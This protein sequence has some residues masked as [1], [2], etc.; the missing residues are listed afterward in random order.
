MWMT[1]Q[2]VHEADFGGQKIPLHKKAD[3]FGPALF[4]LIASERLKL[5]Q[6]TAQLYEIGIIGL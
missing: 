6:H 1:A 3:P 5:G 4:V 2:C